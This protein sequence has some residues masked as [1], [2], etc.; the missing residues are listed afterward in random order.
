MRN[1][2]YIDP[3]GQK[4]IDFLEENGP[5]ELKGHYKNGEVIY[6]A[7]SE[8]PLCSMTKG[9]TRVTS[10]NSM[11]DEHRMEM[12]ATV[13]LDWT[14]DIGASY[15]K[16]EGAARLQEFMEKRDPNTYRVQ[17]DALLYQLRNE[18]QIA[19]KFWIGMD[20]QG[21]EVSYG[22]GVQRRGPGV[23]SVEA[24]LRFNVV[25]HLPKPGLAIAD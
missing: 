20:E 17:E 1:D 2:E 10:I 6:E 13:I 19:N 5:S 7:Q 12:A 14:Q 8:L 18:Q 21:S 25:L 24:T 3:V 9:R 15:D 4:V 22:I 16:I 11:E 23:I